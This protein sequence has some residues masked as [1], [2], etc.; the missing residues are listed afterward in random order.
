MLTFAN[1]KTHVEHALGGSP[2]AQLPS[3]DIVNQAGRQFFN[4]QWN[5]RLK[6]PKEITTNA[7]AK[8]VDLP[9]DFGH[10]VSLYMQSGLTESIQL[11]TLE[12]VIKVRN[13][14]ISTGSNYMATITWPENEVATTPPR[15]ELAPTPSSQDTIVVAYLSGWQQMEQDTET[16]KVPAYAEAAL[17]QMVRAFALGYEEENMS[18]RIL[19][20]EQGPIFQQALTSDGLTQNHYGPLQNGVVNSTHDSRRLPFDAISNPSS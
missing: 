14:S 11:T 15:L 1:L 20:V 3:S 6:G 12:Q 5:F 16:V 17:I 19:E 18:Q 7:N 9:A 4:H 10:M 2:S 13:S 8:Y